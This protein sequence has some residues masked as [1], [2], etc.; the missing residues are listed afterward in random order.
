MQR[1]I[2]TGAW[3]GQAVSGQETLSVAMAIGQDQAARRFTGRFYI[4]DPIR[5]AYIFAGSVAG[6]YSGNLI[7]WVSDTSIQFRARFSSGGLL[8]GTLTLPLS[9][10]EPPV[11]AQ[12]NVRRVTA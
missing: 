1:S 6:S 9:T 12:V 7:Q 3:Q 5:T 4:K 8:S 2:F 10:G 11:V